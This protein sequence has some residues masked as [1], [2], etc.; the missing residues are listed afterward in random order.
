MNRTSAD[1]PVFHVRLDA[2]SRFL[3]RRPHIKPRTQ[4]VSMGLYRDNGKEMETTIMALYRVQGLRFELENEFEY[5]P[6]AP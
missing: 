6:G 3:S 2:V 5:G 1:E 4:I